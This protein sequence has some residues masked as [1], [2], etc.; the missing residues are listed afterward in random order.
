MRLH[1]IAAHDENLV[2]GHKGK[3]P[4]HISDDLKHFKKITMGSPILMGRGVFEEI[5]QKPLPGRRNVVLSSKKWDEVESY[6]DIESALDALKEEDIVYVIGGGQIYRQLIDKCEKMYI[7]E[8]DGQHEGDVF[9]P[10]YKLDLDADWIEISRNT[11]SGYAFVEYM[12]INNLPINKDGITK[13]T[14]TNE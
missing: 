13:T 5:G 4:W 14:Q 3:L 11:Y 8:V 9:F 1:L 7:T 2:I 12:R 6:G 10:D